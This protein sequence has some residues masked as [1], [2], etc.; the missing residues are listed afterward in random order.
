MGKALINVEKAARECME[1]PEL[2][3]YATA[4]KYSVKPNTLS[5]KI[6]TVFF[7]NLHWFFKYKFTLLFINLHCL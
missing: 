5:S 4:K 7:I 3:V 1:N 2:S 6:Y